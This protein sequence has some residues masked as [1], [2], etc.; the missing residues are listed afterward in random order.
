MLTLASVSLAAP[1]CA[2]DELVTRANV[3]YQEG[4]WQGAID[5][6]EAVRSAGFESAGLYYNLGN[7]YFKAGE[8]GQA[9]LAWERALQRSPGDADTRAN[10][11]L[12]RELTADAIEPLP[13]FWLFSVISWW[14]DLLP[15]TLL[16][17]VVAVGWLALAGGAVLR[18]LARAPGMG[19]VGRWLVAAGA[20]TVLLMGTNL[21]ARE[22][23]V[24][25]AERAIILAETVPV[26]SAP[27]EDDDLVLFQVHEGTRVR[28][29][30][31]TGAWAE[32]VLDDGKV[33]WLPL[34]AMDVI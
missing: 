14:V 28:I 16:I 21:V 25:R 34:G 17:T 29:E 8:L 2:Q 7:A 15:R 24:G 33:G 6:Y 22:F 23:G 19:R 4:D 10:L 3:A 32:V 26:R 27:A 5:A 20:V 1:A 30:Q 12:A 13:D 31:R 18:I 9:I 11:T